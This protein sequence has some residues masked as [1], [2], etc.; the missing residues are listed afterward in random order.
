MIMGG[1]HVAGPAPT[2]PPPDPTPAG[3]QSS[4]TEDEADEAASASDSQTSSPTSED[5]ASPTSSETSRQS[6]I[7]N[8]PTVAAANALLSGW[9]PKDV[10]ALLTLGVVPGGEPPGL[11][12][13]LPQAPGVSDLPGWI[14][15]DLATEL[16]AAPNDRVWPAERLRDL[17]GE[18]A[19]KI[20]PEAVNACFASAGVALAKGVTA[21]AY[22]LKWVAA[23]AAARVED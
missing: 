10:T 20:A 23:M 7:A 13:T 18:L 6:E 8:A 9:L 11:G 16:A 2:A 19:S 3:G 14:S 4:A 1:K 12:I 17:H 22:Q 21:L 15:D 5:E